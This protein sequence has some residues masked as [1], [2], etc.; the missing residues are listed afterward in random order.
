MFVCFLLLFFV[1][2][3]FYYFSPKFK[4]PLATTVNF[5][6]SYP[7]TVFV[8]SFFSLV[9]IVPFL[10]PLSLLDR[11]PPLACAMPAPRAACVN[12]ADWRPWV[13]DVGPQFVSGTS[14]R[15]NQVLHSFQ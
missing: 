2:I 3:Y 14:L 5:L 11:L 9:I 6:G 1:F 15:S 13:V 10:L 12:C 7:T 4:N 8:S